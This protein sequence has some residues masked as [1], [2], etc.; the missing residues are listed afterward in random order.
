[1]AGDLRTIHQ[2]LAKTEFKGEAKSVEKIK[3]NVLNLSYQLSSVSFD[4]VSFKDQLIKLISDNFSLEFRIS[5]KGIDSIPWEEINN[6][7][8]RTL[9]LSTRETFQNT[10]KYAEANKFFIQFSSEKKEILLLLKDNGKGFEK[11]KSKIRIG[12]KNQG[13][14]R[15]NPE[16]FRSKIY[17]TRNANKHHYSDK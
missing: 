9:Y 2:K 4:E 16:N 15:R 14:S 7:I 10:L 6:T 13:A 17:R 3:D 5:T 8:K 12:L 11:G 1:M